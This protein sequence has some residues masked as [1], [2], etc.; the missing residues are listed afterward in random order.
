MSVPIELEIAVEAIIYESVYE[1]CGDVYGQNIAVNAIVNN[2]ALLA[3]KAAAP[4]VWELDVDVAYACQLGMTYCAM[5][6]GWIVCNGRGKNISSGVEEGIIASKS[7]A[8]TH[9]KNQIA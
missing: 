9:Y 7:A 1:R 4:L 8:E 3:P 5:A 2:F 6:D